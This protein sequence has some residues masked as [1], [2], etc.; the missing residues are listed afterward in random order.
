M[1]TLSFFSPGKLLIT[2]EYFVLDGASALAVPTL[3]GQEMQV[4][5][6]DDGDHLI[7]WEAFH[8]G[9]L[10]LS[11]KF[12]YENLEI[13]DTNEIEPANFIVKV[14]Q[15][16]KDLNP[17]IF[18]SEKSFNFKTNLQFPADFGLGSSSTLMVNLANW[19]KIDAFFLN[20]KSLGGSGYDIAVA[21][22]NSTIVYQITLNLNQITTVD[23]NPPFL[24]DL[25]LIHLN[26]KQNSRE[27]I[28][29]YRSKQ[30]SSEL[31][32]FFSDLTKQILQISDV[33]K[34]SELME[35]HEKKLSEFLGLETVKSKF[36]AD[37]PVFVKSLGAWGGDFVLSR[38][39]EGYKTYFS[40]KNY[41]R[42]FAWKDLVKQL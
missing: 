23:F 33:E 24:D 20:E 2:S 7:V 8:E 27:G 11:I 3:L 16:I 32:D 6:L 22:E 35:I 10:W 42:V 21:L 30:K 13:L 19:A 39:F 31:V 41:D 15:N 1:N 37:C 14:F 12:D 25:I 28:Q 34:F 9:K 29:L 5:T 17:A 4:E 38:R 18:K 40:D 36:F 26:Q